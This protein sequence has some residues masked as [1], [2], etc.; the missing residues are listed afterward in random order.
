[1]KTKTVYICAECS[2]EAPKWLGKCPSC[3]AWNSF[4]AQQISKTPATLSGRSHQSIE[5]KSLSSLASYDENSSRRLISNINELDRT[6]GGGFVHASVTLLGGE[7]GIGKSTLTIQLAEEISKQNKKL[8]YISGEESLNQVAGRATRLGINSE[9]ILF[10]QENN[11]ET[12]LSTIEQE[13]PDFLII[14]SIQTISS[15]DLPGA[16]G[17][18][19]QTITVT[20]QLIEHCKKKGITLLLIGHVTKEGSLAG[21]KMLEHLVDTVLLFEGDRYSQNRVLRTSKNRFGS[22]NEIGIFAM[23]EK[24][25]AEIKNPSQ[26]FLEGR[27]KTAIGSIFT[28]TIEGNRPLLMEI[29]ALTSKTPFGYPKRTSN[30]FDLTRLHIITAVLQKYSK[31]N[32]SDQDIFV[33][34]IGGFKLKDPSVDLAVALAIA[35]SFY[36]IPITSSLA[37]MGEIGLSGELR[38]ISKL[39]IRLRELLKLGMNQV[40]T[41]NSSELKDNE[42]IISAKSLGEALKAIQ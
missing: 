2:H 6:L 41:P 18:I 31:I 32:L 36:K 17:S 34:V 38:P 30:G 1:M 33:N 14:D 20:E 12:V 40:I 16:P 21:P 42:A 22:T 35:S 26:Q 24:G 10:L 37:V 29:Q 5:A 11:L 23:Q 7:P 15:L 9:A 8:I 4:S 27:S 3:E 13:K 19:S 39:N 28:I 25:L